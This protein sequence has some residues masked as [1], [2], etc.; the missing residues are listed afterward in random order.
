M[1]PDI[2]SIPWEDLTLGTEPFITLKHY[3]THCLTH[4]RPS[5]GVQ[6]LTLLLNSCVCL[7][8]L[9]Q[10]SELSF[11]YPPNEDHKPYLTGSLSEVVLN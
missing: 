11:S 1:S 3:L 9:L 5:A 2:A 8:K 4:G 7:G 6:I 10:C